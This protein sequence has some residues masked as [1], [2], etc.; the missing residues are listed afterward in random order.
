M[1]SKED[2]PSPQRPE[3]VDPL[4]CQIAFT[5]WIVTAGFYEN[6]VNITFGAID[7]AIASGNG[8][9]RI[10]VTSRLRFSRDVGIRLHELLGTILGVNPEN[11]PSTPEPAPIPKN[12]MN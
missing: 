7:H 9:P 10:I 1:S 12:K 5:D 8:L 6:V 4:N 11:T 3:V 2:L